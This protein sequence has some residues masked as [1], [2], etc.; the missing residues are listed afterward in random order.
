MLMSQ[1]LDYDSS[2]SI[3]SHLTRAHIT[4]HMNFHSVTIFYINRGPNREVDGKPAEHAFGECL[5]D[6]GDGN[7][8]IEFGL[9]VSCKSVDSR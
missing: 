5:R 3:P 6:D 4:P 9:E 1:P 7:I 2:S 8:T